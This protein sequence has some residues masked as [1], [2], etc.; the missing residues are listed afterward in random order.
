M[1]SS[2][3][4]GGLGHLACICLCPIAV[5]Y[6]LID[7][8][9]WRTAEAAATAICEAPGCPVEPWAGACCADGFACAA[10]V[11]APACQVAQFLQVRR[12]LSC[13][14][15]DGRKVQREGVSW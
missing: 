1:L 12:L 3:A 7:F 11:P 2:R 4:I 10:A 15:C 6:H 14:H 8:G 9:A 5:P 13:F